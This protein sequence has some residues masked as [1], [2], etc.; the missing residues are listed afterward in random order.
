MVVL[1]T[2]WENRPVKV[3]LCHCPASKPNWTWD[4]NAREATLPNI[5]DAVGAKRGGSGVREPTAWIL[6]GDLNC[7]TN[8][9]SNLCNNYQQYDAEENASV[10]QVVSKTIGHMKPGDIAL[11]QGLRAYQVQTTIG[12]SCGHISDAHDL[13]VVPVSL[14]NAVSSSSGENAPAKPDMAV[15]DKN[16]R[17]QAADDCIADEYLSEPSEEYLYEPSTQGD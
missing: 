16:D 10:R 11:V 2:N 6:G 15:N 7:E 3:G 13:V 17:E 1:N 12:V 8:Y 5:L 9:L 14:L 4:L